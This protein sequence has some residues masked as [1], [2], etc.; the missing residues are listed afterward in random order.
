MESRE[1]LNRGFCKA[2]KI[3]EKQ[4]VSSGSHREGMYQLLTYP[5][6][7][8]SPQ[9]IERVYHAIIKNFPK[10]GQWIEFEVQTGL[11]LAKVLP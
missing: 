3:E 4:I 2:A 5:V 1:R 9:I 10:I 6:S 11:L 7:A 8:N